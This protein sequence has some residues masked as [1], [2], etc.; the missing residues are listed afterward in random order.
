MGLA[1]AQRVV[2]VYRGVLDNGFKAAF[3]RRG[4]QPGHA[5]GSAVIRQ[6]ARQMSLVLGLTNRRLILHGN[7]IADSLAS[8]PPLHKCTQGKWSGSQC[9]RSSSTNAWR[10]GVSQGGTT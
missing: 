6:I 1:A 8:E 2:S 9:S 3:L 5:D 4:R 7:F 10:S